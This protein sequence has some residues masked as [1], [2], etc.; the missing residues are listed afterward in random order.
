MTAVL[1]A[2]DG[3]VDTLLIRMGEASAVAGQDVA[4]PIDLA[5]TATGSDGTPMIVVETN[6]DEI[7]GAARFVGVDEVPPLS[8]Q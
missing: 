3:G 5:T 2:G 6:G 7:A 8:G 1:F 4:L